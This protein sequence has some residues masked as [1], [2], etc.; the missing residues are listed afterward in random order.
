M[1]NSEFKQQF[2][3]QYDAIATHSAP[4]LDDFEISY[5]LTKAQLEIVK[6]YYDPSSNRKNKGFEQS[7][8]RRHDLRNLVVT[9]TTNDIVFS[10]NKISEDSYFFEIPDEVYL[11]IYESARL[12]NKCSL[13]EFVSVVPRTHDEYNIQIKN[14]FKSPDKNRV[15]RLD[16]QRIDNKKVVELISSFPVLE[17]KIR[18]IKYP[19]PIIITNLNLAFPGENLTIE[20]VSQETNCELEPGV[21]QEILDRAVELALNDYRPSRLENKISLDQRNE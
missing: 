15:W 10:T 4:G 12:D 14:P 18:Y 20:G 7:E 5:Y 3:I 8:K 11:L 6:N 16:V 2:L 13:N 19:K 9:H 21:H 17:Y 1:T